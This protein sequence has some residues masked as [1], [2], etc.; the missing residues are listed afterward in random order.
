MLAAFRYTVAFTT[1]LNAVLLAPSFF[2]TVADF[3]GALILVLLA[4]FLWLLLAGALSFAGFF[5]NRVFLL[6]CLATPSVA[7]I[8]LLTGMWLLPL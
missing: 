1:L 5:K 7:F 3:S 2:S 8:V 4:N 6:W